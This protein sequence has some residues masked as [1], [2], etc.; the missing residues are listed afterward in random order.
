VVFTGAGLDA[1]LKQ[2]IRDTLP[3]LLAR[4]DQAHT[5]FE[6]FARER[7][8]TGEIADTAMIARY[9]TSEDPR[10]RLIEDYIY[11][12]EPPV[13][14]GGGQGRGGARYR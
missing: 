4:N 13:G 3:G 8:G 12:L 5:K 11:K 10:T 6:A 1:V 2:L 14:R 7:L 9:L